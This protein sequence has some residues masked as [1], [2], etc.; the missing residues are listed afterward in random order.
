MTPR[1]VYRV[2]FWRKVRCA[3][4]PANY[5]PVILIRGGRQ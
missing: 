2:L 5:R 4:V 3:P 1:E